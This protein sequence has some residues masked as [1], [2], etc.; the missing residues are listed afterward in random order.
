MQKSDH[1]LKW[2]ERMAG[3]KDE[4]TEPIPLRIPPE[5]PESGS[6]W[7]AL[8]AD[9]YWL[10]VRHPTGVELDALDALRSREVTERETVFDA[11]NPEN[12]IVREKRYFEF[13][14]GLL[15]RKAVEF[16]LVVKGQ[17]PDRDEGKK[18]SLRKLTGDPS[19]DWKFISN[20]GPD[21][22]QSLVAALCEAIF[23]TEQEQV[24]K[25]GEESSG[26]SESSTANQPEPTPL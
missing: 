26:T 21:L 16:G 7:E 13:S 22:F 25:E 24:V 15:M 2:L 11:A 10:V 3:P 8:D 17:V 5:D 20:C 6:D 12:S 18:V 14:A 9:T 4:T 1:K 23:S 19:K